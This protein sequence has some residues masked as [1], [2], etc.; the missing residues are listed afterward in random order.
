MCAQTYNS[1]VRMHKHTPINYTL[2]GLFIELYAPFLVVGH[3]FY[4]RFYDPNNCLH[5]STI[6]GQKHTHHCFRGLA[7]DSRENLCQHY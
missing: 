5:Y 2:F 6:L 3:L 7:K 4:D 1:T